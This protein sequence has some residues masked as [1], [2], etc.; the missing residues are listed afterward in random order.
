MWHL[1]TVKMVIWQ[2]CL[3]Q[4]ENKVPWSARFSELN[5]GIVCIC[6]FSFIHA[7]F[8]S[9][10]AP[11]FCSVNFNF[12]SFCLHYTFYIILMIIGF[13]CF[14]KYFIHTC[15]LAGMIDQH[16]DLFYLYCRPYKTLYY[17][18]VSSKLFISFLMAINLGLSSIW[19]E[20]SRNCSIFP[21]KQEDHPHPMKTLSIQ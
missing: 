1:S 6:V 9:Q 15:L 2:I 8:V 5:I 14:L 12:S 17:L 21:R 18:A 16:Y 19:T 3:N 4:S 20:H 13:V 10:L 7:D 11:S